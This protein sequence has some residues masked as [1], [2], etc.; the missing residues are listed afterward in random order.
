MTAGCIQQPVQPCPEV[1]D[2]PT[3]PTEKADRLAG[4]NRTLQKDLVSSRSEIEDLERRVAD[5]EIQLLQK[6]ALNIELQRRAVLRQQRLDSAI[7]EVVRTKSKLRTVESK[8]EAASTIAEAEIAVKSLQSRIDNDENK[9]QIEVLEKAKRLLGQSTAEFKAR[10]FGGAL[11]LA[12][13]SKNQ[14]ASVGGQFQGRDEGD[15]LIGETAFA[16]PLRLKVIKNTNLRTGPGLNYK[17]SNTLKSGTVIVGHGY[18]ENWIRI[19]T[20]NDQ[21]GWVHQSLVTAR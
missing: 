3:C 5:L 14:V 6:E 1:P 13:Q 21:T 16:H 4:E 12:V 18:K 10:N 19:D 2:C 9:D 20:E 7:T 8:A 15:R 17:V 11:Y